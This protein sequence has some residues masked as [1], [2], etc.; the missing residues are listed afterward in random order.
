MLPP[1]PTL[2]TPGSRT[3]SHLAGEMQG[4]WAVLR[5]RIRM[6]PHGFGLLYPHSKCGF[7]MRMGSGLSYVKIRAEIL[8]T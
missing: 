8:I 1:H 6:D 5:I 7:H 3:Q 4:S 2:E